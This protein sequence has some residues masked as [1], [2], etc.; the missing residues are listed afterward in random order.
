[1]FSSQKTKKDI[2][3]EIYRQ[4][5]TIFRLKDIAILVGEESFQSLNK[6]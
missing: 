3:L 5:R 4:N 6:K 1:M 2:I